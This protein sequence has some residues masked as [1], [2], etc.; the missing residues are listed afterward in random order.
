MF[1]RVVRVTQNLLET[2]DSII[3]LK[4]KKTSNNRACL[5][6]VPVRHFPSPTRGLNLDYYSQDACF[7]ISFWV[8]GTGNPDCFLY[9]TAVLKLM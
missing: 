8:P 5:A 4:S 6:A 1:R 3:D 7:Y 9:G 2:R